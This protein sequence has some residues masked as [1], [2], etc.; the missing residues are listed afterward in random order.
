MGNEGVNIIY[1]ISVDPN[2]KAKIRAQ[3]E[4]ALRR[5]NVRAAASPSLLWLVELAEALDANCAAVRSVVERAALSADFRALEP[6]KALRSRVG[7]GPK[8]KSDCYLCL[9]EGNVLEFAIET[10]EKRAPLPDGESL[11]AATSP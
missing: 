1:D 8:E 7:C 10:I 2:V 9:R 11:P 6:L 3:A 5:P 4:R